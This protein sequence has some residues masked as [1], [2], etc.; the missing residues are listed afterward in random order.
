MNGLMRRYYEWKVKEI[1][2]DIQSLR[3]YVEDCMAVASYGPEEECSGVLD[4]IH[5]LEQKR[6]NIRDKLQSKLEII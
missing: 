2:E 6:N 4:D 3:K 5:S 1:D